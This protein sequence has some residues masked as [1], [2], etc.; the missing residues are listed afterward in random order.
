[1]LALALYLAYIVE[2]GGDFMAGRFF[3][4]PLCV[5]VA[6]L[7]QIELP[8]RWSAAWLLPALGAI[9]LAYQTD[10]SPLHPRAEK[11]AAR[12]RLQDC[13]VEGKTSDERFCWSQT[14]SLASDASFGELPVGYW[15]RTGEDLEKAA[16]AHP[17]RRLVTE[18]LNIGMIGYY[19]GP[20]VHVVD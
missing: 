15:R 5:A 8:K 14:S 10:R 1:A 13:I 3:T 9:W 16:A 2:I 11:A 20:N 19:A 7:A 6:L 17:G 12:V 18:R 4:S